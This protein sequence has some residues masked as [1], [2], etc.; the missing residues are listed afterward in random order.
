MTATT[1]T[2][3]QILDLGGKRVT[4]GKTSVV[5]I[6]SYVWTKWLG[7]EV[8]RNVGFAVAKA[9]LGGR[10]IE[11]R[12]AQWMLHEAEVYWTAGKI[13]FGAG[14]AGYKKAVLS[15]LDKALASTG[16][17]PAAETAPEQAVATTGRPSI[18]AERPTTR[19]AMSIDPDM[20]DQVDK[21]AEAAGITRSAW[22]RRSIAA[23][24]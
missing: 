19:F 24:L 1:Y 5:Q 16:E 4:R 9:T 18:S 17:A 20:L 15:G 3:R 23:A 7:L 21:A 6:P 22:I 11:S 10:P 13:R 2:L 8:E 14:M 12:L